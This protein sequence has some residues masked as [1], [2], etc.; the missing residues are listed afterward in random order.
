MNKILISGFEPFGEY[1]V[2][3]SQ[4]IIKRLYDKVTSTGLQYVSCVLPVVRNRS[5]QILLQAIEEHSPIAVIAI[6]Q[7]RCTEI[8]LERIAI[9]VD[10][11]SIKDNAGVQVC[12]VP[13]V[14]GAPAA[15]WSTLPIREIRNTLNQNNIPA[16]ISNSAGTYVCNHVFYQLQHALYGATIPSGFV[17]VPTVLTDSEC[18]VMSIETMVLAIDLIAQSVGRYIEKN[19]Q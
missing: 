3:S 16:A 1:S 10:D 2:N 18:S 5:A 17:H 19:I 11:F 4:E 8:L 6:G 15:Y 13:I 14:S 7:A 12:D 9:N